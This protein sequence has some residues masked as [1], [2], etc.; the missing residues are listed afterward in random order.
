MLIWSSTSF[1]CG[2]L[3]GYWPAISHERGSLHP[4]PV[5]YTPICQ[6]LCC[7]PNS[8]TLSSLWPT[9]WHRRFSTRGNSLLPI[10]TF[11]TV[12]NSDQAVRADCISV[13]ALSPLPPG[14]ARSRFKGRTKAHP[15][16][17]PCIF[18]TYCSTRMMSAGL[19]L[20]EIQRPDRMSGCAS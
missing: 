2:V 7:F 13:G 3:V 11:C 4:S 1:E 19:S 9:H 16:D 10:A 14:N 8:N 17:C 20:G 18:L 6:A 12:M 5:R 15:K